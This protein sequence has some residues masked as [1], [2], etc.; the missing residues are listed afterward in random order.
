MGEGEG[1][2][3][4]AGAGHGPGSTE[5]V[6]SVAGQAVDAAK[7]DRPARRPRPGTRIACVALNSAPNNDRRPLRV[8]SNLDMAERVCQHALRFAN[9]R[10]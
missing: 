7:E 10:G 1:P 3:P 6:K 2:Y 5:K 8:N 4:G 9:C